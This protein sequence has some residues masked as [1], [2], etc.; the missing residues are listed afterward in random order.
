MDYFQVSVFPHVCVRWG[1]QGIVAVS[2]LVP[3]VH[4]LSFSTSASYF[5][6]AKCFWIPSLWMCLPGRLRS[7]QSVML[8][9]LLLVGTCSLSS[10]SASLW[11]H[12]LV[13]LGGNLLSPCVP[14]LPHFC[15]EA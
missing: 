12:R 6:F 1:V 10:Y 11:D 3:Y 4:L 9:T 5:T 14:P 2:P 13:E 15:I 7:L 8:A